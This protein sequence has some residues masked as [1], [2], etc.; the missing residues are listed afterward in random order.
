MVLR[1]NILIVLPDMHSIDTTPCKDVHEEGIPGVDRLHNI[2][3]C[4][5]VCATFR[6]VSNTERY[7]MAFCL[8]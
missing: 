4:Q 8:T 6:R 1:D 2:P 5:L 7:R 3:S